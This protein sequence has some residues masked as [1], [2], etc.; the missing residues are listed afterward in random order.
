M[1][2]HVSVDELFSLFNSNKPATL[3][4]LPIY[5]VVYCNDEKSIIF[6]QIFCNAVQ[7]HFIII[8]LDGG[9]VVSTIFCPEFSSHSFLFIS[10][11]TVGCCL[12]L[13]L[14]LTMSSLTTTPTKTKEGGEEEK[15]K[16]NN[17]I[18]VL[19]PFVTNVDLT[20]GRNTEMLFAVTQDVAQSM[21]DSASPAAKD[22]GNRV[23]KIS[24]LSNVSSPIRHN[25]VKWQVEE[26]FKSKKKLPVF[27]GTANLRDS[28]IS[29][30]QQQTPGEDK[31]L[32]A[33]LPPAPTPNLTTLTK[34][35]TM[36]SAV[37]RNIFGSERT[38]E[39]STRSKWSSATPV[40]DNVQSD[41]RAVHLLGPNACPNHKDR[42][43]GQIY[44]CS[45]QKSV[46]CKWS[47]RISKSAA[48]PGQYAVQIIGNHINHLPDTDWTGWVNKKKGLPPYI[49]EYVIFLRNNVQY[50]RVTPDLFRKEVE[51][52]FKA[53]PLFNDLQSREKILQKVGNYISNKGRKEYVCKSANDQDVSITYLRDL[54][55]FKDKYSL[56][57]PDEY[58]PQLILSEVHMQEVAVELK[59][60]GVVG[61][62]FHDDVPHRDLLSLPFDLSDP[63]VKKRVD[64]LSSK[65]KH[66][67]TQ[68][69]IVFSSLML[70]RNMCDC[71]HNHQMKVV[72]CTDS[73][74][75]TI[76][77]DYKL[78]SFGVID[79]AFREKGGK[80]YHSQSFRPV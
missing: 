61:K 64:E 72:G 54:Q 43:D 12:C 49:L 42:D 35:P 24:K 78:F 70:L 36:P 4:Y 15:T 29:L 22:F 46:A 52:H 18:E 74:H 37:A 75:N 77:N 11:S 79:V 56:K 51:L 41:F 33:L 21:K 71:Y 40:Y 44:Y 28:Q 48:Y 38:K 39:P 45:E 26:Y 34:D 69:S 17:I 9:S 59:A 7:C 3:F 14:I 65:R 16:K 2:I 47:A 6:Y 76:C 73:T 1:I 31:T 62:S 60:Q 10:Q 5:P 68:T 32:Q 63:K 8:Q 53:D 23:K 20:N 57:V 80:K 19:D 27:G 66:P 55:T 50:Q 58:S 25:Y 67:S 30:H 13:G